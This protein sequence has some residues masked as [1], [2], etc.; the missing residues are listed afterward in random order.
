MF[1]E[2]DVD[3]SGLL[4]G[5][6]LQEG[7][8]KM[9][10]PFITKAQVASIIAEFDDD[11]DMGISEEEFLTHYGRMFERRDSSITGRI[12]QFLVFHPP[13]RV[14]KRRSQRFVDRFRFG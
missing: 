5:P 10:A 8:R 4:T 1:N 11:G 14:D 13:K 2:L 9:G 3:H 7:L 6:E 12:I